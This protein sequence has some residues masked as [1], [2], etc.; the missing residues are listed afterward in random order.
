MDTNSSG[1][2]MARAGRGRWFG[3]IASGVALGAVA[4]GIV[5]LTN[6][7]PS[8][9]EASVPAGSQPS[10]GT[11]SGDTDTPTRTISVSGEGKVTIVPDTATIYLGVQT[12]ADTANGALKAANE[13]AQTLITVLKALNIDEKD[14][15]TSNVSLWPRYDNLGRKIIGYTSTNDL[16]VKIRKLDTAGDVLQA[17]AGYVGDEIRFNGISFSLDDTSA[18][19]SDARKAAI[20]DAKKRAEDYAGAAGVSVGAVV[21]ISEVSAP[22]PY[23][24]YRGAEYAAADTAA[25]SVPIQAGTQEY[26]ITVTVVYEIA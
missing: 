13:K 2:G 25:G 12:D 15:Q 26:S 3:L 8:P 20:A 9:S 16:T 4:V 1:N 22:V 18:A 24:V 17:A 10:T 21:A 23:P 6:D 19:M 14:I 11:Q 7:G 5:A